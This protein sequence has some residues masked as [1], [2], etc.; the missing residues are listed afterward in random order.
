MEFYRVYSQINEEAMAWDAIVY[1]NFAAAQSAMRNMMAATG[2]RMNIAAYISAI[3]KG[4]NS[5]YRKIIADALTNIFLETE[6]LSAEK[7]IQMKDTIEDFDLDCCFGDKE[8]T[9]DFKAY[10]ESGKIIIIKFNFDQ[11]LHVEFDINTD[12]GNNNDGIIGSYFFIK[13]RNGKFKANVEEEIKRVTLDK[14]SN[15]ANIICVYKSL[16]DNAREVK[17]EIEEYHID[18]NY[19]AR[20]MT[21]KEI[22]KSSQ[23]FYAKQSVL[24]A[25]TIV[26]HIHTLIQL[27]I[28]IKQYKVSKEEKEFWEAR[29]IRCNE[30]YEVDIDFLDKVPEPTDASKLG[31]GVKPLLILFVL[32]DA[33]KP[34]RQADIIEALRQ[35]YTV[36]I[37]RVAVGRHIELLNRFGYPIEKCKDGYIFKEKET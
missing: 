2:Q 6:P 26:K 10:V 16:Y 33:E 5:G 4:K 31:V 19:I 11:K 24:S 37:G 32:K 17:R 8:P 30:G 1:D 23:N 34:M 9:A 27:G 12:F 25:E 3:L 13:D 18:P 21:T 20:G 28:P 29:N 15:S 36:D 35:K 22:Q 14:E 7:I